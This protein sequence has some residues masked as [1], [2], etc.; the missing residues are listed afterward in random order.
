MLLN[1][2]KN[3]YFF[4][5][6]KGSSVLLMCVVKVW[7]FKWKKIKFIYWCWDSLFNKRRFCK[8]VIFSNLNDLRVFWGM[9]TYENFKFFKLFSK[10]YL[11]I[12][13]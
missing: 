6:W 11:N 3:V 5:L 10:V 9:F 7:K 12:M 8:K 1:D 2:F 4:Y 13:R